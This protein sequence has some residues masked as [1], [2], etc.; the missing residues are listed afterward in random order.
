MET[1]ILE[2]SNCGARNRVGTHSAGLRPIC[3]RCGTALNKRDED[4]NERPSI[5]N[6][7]S[8]LF[9]TVLL[10][11][12]FGV[13]C[14]GIAITPSL[15]RK[16]FSQIIL[17]ETQKTEAMKKRQ[18]K[19][20]TDKKAALE[21]ELSAIN[22]MELRRKAMEQYNRELEERKAYDKRFAIS[23][24]EKAQLQM[25][26]L[27]SDSTKSFHDAIRAVAREASPQGSDISI[28]E[29]DKG[30][31]LHIDFD[32]SSMTSGESGTQTKHDTKDSLRKE[33]ISLISRV[34]NDIFQFSK[35]IDLSSIHVGCR[36]HVRTTYPN[37]TTRDENTILY[38]IRIRKD[39]IPQLTSNPFLDVYSTTQYFEVDEDNF[40]DIEIHTTRL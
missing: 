26:N 9:V 18:E 10:L 3:G 11:I 12:L 13:A 30:I 38:K 31:A 25:L 35:A 21:N 33:V 5:H 27:A 19:D 8:N 20:F 17:E 4:S 7:R 28:Q 39:R 15:L 32:M 24:R 16:D 2:C 6:G 29:S 1:E 14:S 23:P 37:G 36:H 40:A 34:T 22:A